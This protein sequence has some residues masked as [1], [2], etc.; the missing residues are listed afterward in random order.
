MYVRDELGVFPECAYSL[1]LSISFLLTHREAVT[2]YPAGHRLASFCARTRRHENLYLC[3]DTLKAKEYHYNL[4]LIHMTLIKLDKETSLFSQVFWDSWDVWYLLVDSSE[5]TSVS[6]FIE[7]VVMLNKEAGTEVFYRGHADENW[8]LKPSIFRKPNGVEI[9]HQ[10]FRDM[11]AHTP[12][13]FSGCKSALD[14]LVQMQHYELP[15]RLLDVTM[16]PLIALYFACQSRDDAEVDSISGLR[17]ACSALS[18]ALG[19]VNAFARAIDK[20][21]DKPLKEKESIHRVLNV[22]R[23]VQERVRVIPPIVSNEDVSSITFSV[24]EADVLYILS[25]VKRGHYSA[26]SHYI[27]ESANESHVQFDVRIAADMA[28]AMIVAAN[29][30]E[31]EWVSSVVST[32]GAIAGAG[33]GAVAGY[34]ALILAEFNSSSHAVERA[35]RAI[36]KAV[37]EAAIAAR[38][39]RGAVYLFSIPE[40]RVKHYDSDTVSVLANL[41]KCSDQEIDVYTEEIKVMGEG[42]ALEKFNKQAGIR[43]LLRQIK[44]EKPYFEPLIRPDDLSSIFLVKAK[45]GN[46]RIIN[47]AGAFFIFGL[48]LIPPAEGRGGRLT[49]RVGHKIP[50]DWIRHKFIIPKDKKQ[51]ILDE[52]ARMGIT[53]SYLFPEMDRYA[54]ELKKKYK[55]E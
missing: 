23:L 7:K 20:L 11:V 35:A 36:A 21:L 1:L 2:G 48:G 55:L 26:I 4:I 33:V 8:E 3:V 51:D 29:E 37:V 38:D 10:L 43:I 42:E 13:S 19:L 31:V 32:S 24:S 52:L 45:Y 46:P 9:E 41:A 49:K 15:T 39:S 47:Q 17:A 30:K 50:S 12:Q 44:E 22:I 34:I 16:N 6:D 53:E 40:A 28:A 5:V 25:A 14:Y 18:R 27:T 54:K